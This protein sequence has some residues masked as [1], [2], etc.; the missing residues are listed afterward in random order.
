[1][2]R[3]QFSLPSTVAVD[4]D[5]DQEH[6]AGLGIV[7]E[8]TGANLSAPLTV[9]NIP[10][11][12]AP[13][14][15]AELDDAERA[16]L[17]VCE[18]AVSGLQTAFT[19]AGKA[20][21]TINQARLYRETHGSFE[22][23]LID[24]W[25]MKRAHAYRLIEAWPVAASLSPRGDTPPEKHIR[26]L[27]PVS[28]RHGVE[29]ARAVYEELREQDVPVTTTRVTEAVQALPPRLD[30]PEEARAAVR[31]AVAE[32]R[33]T[34]P[35]RPV[36]AD[37]QE[38][39]PEEAGGGSAVEEGARAVAILGAAVEEQRRLYDRLAGVVPVALVHDPGRAEHLL[40]DLRQYANR[41]A[42]RARPPAAVEGTE[43]APEA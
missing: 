34:R 12:Y 33:L 19:V 35:R 16:D 22:A 36:E 39:E 40:H 3:R 41:T 21:A 27:L 1:M 17:A 25:G 5:E 18:R 29:A 11:P 8:L 10:A 23:Y 9:A 31:T 15:A 30:S 42:W 43:P 20:L 26:A 13:R 32:G 7:A 28:K 37:V 38:Q 24:R 4:D 2:S 14:D 6:D